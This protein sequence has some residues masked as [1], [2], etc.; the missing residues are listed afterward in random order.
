M[1]YKISDKVLLLT[2][3]VPPD[4]HHAVGLFGCL[5]LL[6]LLEYHAA[7]FNPLSYKVSV[8]DFDG[9]VADS[10]P[11]WGM[12]DKS[13]LN[14]FGVVPDQAFMISLIPLSERECSRLFQEK[15]VKL[16]IEEIIQE[17]HAYMQRAYGTVVELKP[18]VVRVLDYLKGGGQKLIIFSSTPSELIRISLRKN[19]IEGY[20]DDVISA[21]E[22]GLSKANV[23]SFRV[24]AR[25][26]GYE[27]EE[28]AFYDDNVRALRNA[29]AAG[30]AAIGVY[31]E[32]S[33]QT[34]EEIKSIVDCYVTDW[35]SF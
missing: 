15:G 20:F 24:F 23:E 4:F 21:S 1:N 31:D 27:P 6:P 34:Q 12:A 10:M 22:R 28:I 9:T 7:M 26:I 19:G 3:H 14:R 32:Y 30:L 11:T 33:A 8:L 5:V 2:T 25:A 35:A 29:K 17:K 13:I 18:G 16:G